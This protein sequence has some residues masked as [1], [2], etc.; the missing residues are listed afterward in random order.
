MNKSQYKILA[1]S[2]PVGAIGTGL[3]GGVELTLLNLVKEMTRRGHNVD[4]VAPEGSVVNPFSIKQIPGM[5]QIPAQNQKRTDP[6]FIPC[7]SVLANMWD[8][9]YKV[10]LDYDIIINFAYDWLPL[11]L[12]PFFK[13]PIAHLISM[14]SLNNAMDDMIEKIVNQYPTTIAVHGQTQASTF[15]FSEKLKCLKNGMDLSIYQFCDSP[16]KQIGW[17]GRI[18]PEKGLEDAIIASVKSGIPLKIFGLLQDKLYWQQIYEKYNYDSIEYKGF[19]STVDLQK[20]VG[21]C[22][23]ILIT[24]KWIEAYGN[25]AIEALACGV[26]VIAYSRG[27]L[28]EIV[29]HGTTGWLVEPDN[30]DGLIHAISCVDQIN[31]LTCRQQAESEYSLQ[32]FGDRVEN[33]LTNIVKSKFF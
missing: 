3:G 25:V 1:V 20:E 28:T 2:T 19:L 26:P 30:I 18:A 14:S 15:S 22:L 9:A 11:Y 10:Q 21:Q 27:G 5:L 33:W 16:K 8:Y 4:I 7:D 29:Q 13:R 23:A 12:T 17:M 32:A 6:I 24:P 31:R